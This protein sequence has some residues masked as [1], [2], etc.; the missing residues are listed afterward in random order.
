MEVSEKSEIVATQAPEPGQTVRWDLF[1]ASFLTREA[2]NP[3]TESDFDWMIPKHAVWGVE[4]SSK[5]VC[6]RRF[7]PSTLSLFRFHYSPF[8]PE[9]PDTQATQ[10]Q[11]W[12]AVLPLWGSLTWHGR[13]SNE[14]RLARV[15]K[16]LPYRGEYKHFFRRQLH[17]KQMVAVGW[18]LQ[19]Q[20]SHGMRMEMD[21]KNWPACPN[22]FEKI[23]INCF[24]GHVPTPRFH[25]RKMSDWSTRDHVT[26][27]NSKCLNTSIVCLFQWKED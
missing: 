11:S 27:P 15:S 21:Q 2:D 22:K 16:T 5:S 10:W 8:P 26:L 25:R 3:M 13:R 1:Q 19:K 14:R 23:P 9:T 7:S 12:I 6:V 4:D 18:E 20:F 24:E 17:R